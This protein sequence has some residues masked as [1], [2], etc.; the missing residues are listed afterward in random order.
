MYWKWMEKQISSWCINGNCINCKTKDI[1][2]L[3]MLFPLQPYNHPPSTICLV[4][5]KELPMQFI[6][7]NCSTS[8]FR[9][10][11]CVC[12]KE[13]NEIVRSRHNQVSKHICV[14]NM[15]NNA[16]EHKQTDG[17]TDWL[18]SWHGMALAWLVCMHF[19]I[20]LGYSHFSCYHH[21]LG[22][23]VWESS[24][25]VYRCTSLLHF[26]ILKLVYFT[27]RFPAPENGMCRTEPQALYVPFFHGLF[28]IRKCYSIAS[29]SVRNI[30]PFFGTKCNSKWHRSIE[31]DREKEFEQLWHCHNKTYK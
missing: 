17:L 20:I 31:R 11:F 21:Y 16:S 13:Y 24:L 10:K 15:L 4:K 9:Q 26:L 3:S 1:H 29:L 8:F 14:Q 18:A 25:A 27:N 5:S 12:Y 6:D 19:I 2:L 28:I 22:V 23:C 30:L 7:V